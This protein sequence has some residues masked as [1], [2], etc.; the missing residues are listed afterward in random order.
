MTP[1]QAA[2][3]LTKYKEPYYRTLSTREKAVLDADLEKCR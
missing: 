2:G 1:R 3:S